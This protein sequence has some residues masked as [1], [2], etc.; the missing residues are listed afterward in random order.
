MA[1]PTAT[2]LSQA[3][4]LQLTGHPDAKNK[5]GSGHIRP[6]RVFF[7][8]LPDRTSA[9]LYGSWVRKNGEL[10]DA[11]VDQLYRHDDAWPDW[12]TE[13]ARQHTPADRAV[14]ADTLPAWLQQRFDPRGADWEQLSDDDRAYWQHEA[15]AVRRAVT[16]NG[17]K[18]A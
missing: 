14:E 6:E 2:P 8:Y 3:V 16:R 13:L 7:Y 17:F 9:H 15:A 10:T 5:Y 4:E 1:E 18:E 12:L 11:P